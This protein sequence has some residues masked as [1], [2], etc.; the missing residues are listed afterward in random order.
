MDP[1]PAAAPEPPIGTTFDTYWIEVWLPD[2]GAWMPM[3][4]CRSLLEAN[5]T[6]QGHPAKHRTFRIVYVL[7][8]HPATTTAPAGTVD[9]RGS[10][11]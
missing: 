7:R 3:L 2:V 10:R 4:D 11:A 6:I 9:H 1:K 5:E 8:V